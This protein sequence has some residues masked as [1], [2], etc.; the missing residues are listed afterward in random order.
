MAVLPNTRIIQIQSNSNPFRFVSSDTDLGQVHRVHLKSFILPNTEYNLNSKTNRVV[1]TATDMLPVGNIPQGQ[2]TISDL[3]TALKLVLDVASAPNTFTI[4][5]SP[6]TRKL[7]FVKSGGSQF[8][9][10]YESPIARIIGQHTAK[11]SVALSLTTNSIP[12]LSGLR[13]AVINSYTLGRFM[14][15]E[16]D[17]PEESQKSNVLGALPMTAI[18]GGTLKYESDESTLNAT[19]FNG[20]KNVSNFD[21]ALVDSTGGLLELNGC[22]FIMSLEAHILGSA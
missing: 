9:I 13:M 10:G 22:E 15:S 3:L 4:T 2:Y 17:T 16:G 18:F 11:T 20:Y 6:L 8:T 7:T 19:Y 5:Q 21:I 1:I 14:I 12:D